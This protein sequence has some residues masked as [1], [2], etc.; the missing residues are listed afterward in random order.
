ML[1]LRLDKGLILEEF[2]AFPENRSSSPNTQVRHS[3]APGDPYTL[4]T[5][6]DACTLMSNTHTLI[7]TNTNK[8]KENKSKPGVL[9]HSLKPNT[10]GTDVGGAPV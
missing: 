4:P 6:M 8:I 7:Y 10:L 2:A 5:S 9:A 1:T 3:Q